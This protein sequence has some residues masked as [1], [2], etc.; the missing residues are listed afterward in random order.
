MVNLLLLSD[1]HCL[2]ENLSPMCVS[3]IELIVCRVNRPRVHVL[4]TSNVSY[5]VILLTF[6]FML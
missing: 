4:I 6:D 5:S 1:V 2:K 3:I